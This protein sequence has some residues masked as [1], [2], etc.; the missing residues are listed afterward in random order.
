[1]YCICVYSDEL[2]SVRF[3]RPHKIPPWGG[4][5]LDVKWLGG[6][7]TVCNDAETATSPSPRKES[8]IPPLLI[9]LKLLI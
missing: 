2:I 9:F 3:T 4:V 5:R 7:S 6:V 1:M 8:H